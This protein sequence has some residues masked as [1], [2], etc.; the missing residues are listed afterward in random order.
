MT[1][2]E[3]QIEKEKIIS[4]F[5]KLRKELDERYPNT[6]G[7]AY[8][9]CY[10]KH[11]TVYGGCEIPHIGDEK[12]FPEYHKFN[13]DKDYIS[14]KYNELIFSLSKY[15]KGDIVVVGC[16]DSIEFGEIYNSDLE[17]INKPMHRLIGNYSKYDEDITYMIKF[18]KSFN[19]WKY[20]SSGGSF[21]TDTCICSFVE[22]NVLMKVSLEEM[23]EMKKIPTDGLKIMYPEL[24]PI[25]EYDEKNDKI[26]NLVVGFVDKVQDKNADVN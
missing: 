13:K 20:G 3:R 8:L 9:S 7:A 26:K 16:E 24:F 1:E 18:E 23:E 12:F 22:N 25:R 17:T 14:K 11:I 5:N 19:V 6:D 2:T 4:E 15:K 10:S 21:G